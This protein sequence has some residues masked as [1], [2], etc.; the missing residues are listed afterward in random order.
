MELDSSALGFAYSFPPL[1][2]S[3]WFC[4]SVSSV[5]LWLGL[6]CLTKLRMLQA[7]LQELEWFKPPPCCKWDVK[8]G[9]GTK[10]QQQRAEA[11]AYADSL[12]SLL[13]RL[14]RDYLVTVGIGED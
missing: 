13:E 5:E 1:G 12:I 11:V 7:L 14:L 2:C 8:H 9:Q 6:C 10:E 4:P 3:G